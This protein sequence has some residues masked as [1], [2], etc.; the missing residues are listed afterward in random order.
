[1]VVY[2][3]PGVYCEPRGWTGSGAPARSRR[4]MMLLVALLS[5]A[6][7]VTTGCGGKANK[8]AHSDDENAGGDNANQLDELD[9]GE[10]EALCDHVRDR[11]E[12]HLGSDF[13][14]GVCVMYIGAEAESV[15][16]CEQ[17]TQDYCDASSDSSSEVDVSEC[18]DD[19]STVEDCE[20]T[21]G[22]LEDCLDAQIEV[23]DSISK[24]SCENVMELGPDSPSLEDLPAECEMLSER[25]PTLFE[26]NQQDVQPGTGTGDPIPVPVDGPT[27]S[28]DIDGANVEVPLA[29]YG[30]SLPG[31]ERNWV[32][33]VPDGVELRLWGDDESTQGLLN[34]PTGIP[35]GSDSGSTFICLDEVQLERES[36]GE[37]VSW[38][39][40]ELSMLDACDFEGGLPLELE[41]D[42]FYDVEGE[43]RGESVQWVNM[44]YTCWAGCA[45]QFEA[46]GVDVELV[47]ESQDDFVEGEEMTIVSSMLLLTGDG[48]SVACGGGGTALVNGE[49][50]SVS[51]DEFGAPQSC[52][53]EPVDGELS[54]PL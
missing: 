24:L 47:L 54:G 3:E 27:V 29:S 52:P 17:L 18:V 23:Y 1:M 32:T 42:V 9:G 16:Q 12:G 22:E 36:S 40:T 15:A 4:T 7:F 51:I 48:A 43:F 31:L 53:G 37:V 49:H 28:G 11:F 38:S 5:A 21:V 41:F 10:I 25:C 39:S 45:F 8:N 20:V 46:D 34:L 13:E 50:I 6:L 26:S 2:Y 44:G 14:Q 35:G 33:S 30:I 19:L